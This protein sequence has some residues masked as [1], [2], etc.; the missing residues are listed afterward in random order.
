MKKSKFR[1]LKLSKESISKLEQSKIGGVVPAGTCEGPC[2]GGTG[3]CN[4]S[5]GV[6]YDPE[7]Y[8][9]WQICICDIE[10]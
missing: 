9:G 5:Q 8:S 7:S 6:C 10:F 3:C 2:E 4:G 1:K